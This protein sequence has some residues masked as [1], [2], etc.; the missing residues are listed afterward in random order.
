MEIL[1]SAVSRTMDV[2]LVKEAYDRM[3]R[4]HGNELHEPGVLVHSDQGSQYLSTTFQQMLSD[5]GFLQSVSRRGNSQ[6][7]APMESFFGRMNWTLLPFVSPMNPPK[8]WWRIIF[9]PTTIPFI[10]MT[11]RV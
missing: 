9:M 1:G 5:D 10:R 7:N 2:A 4:E 3:K 6:D 8:H 11:L